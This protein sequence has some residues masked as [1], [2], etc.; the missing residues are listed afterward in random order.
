MANSGQQYVGNMANINQAIAQPDY[1]GTAL[2]T[3]QN[4]AG[5]YQSGQ[6][7]KQA[8]AN[9]NLTR[10][11]QQGQ[12]DLGSINKTVA[13]QRLNNLSIRATGA[14]AATD[15]SRAQKQYTDALR[16]QIGQ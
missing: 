13:Q 4:M 16:L 5:A 15:A 12:I 10:T 8:T 9:A 6:L 3:A 1:L 11:Y 2:G 14:R 7:S